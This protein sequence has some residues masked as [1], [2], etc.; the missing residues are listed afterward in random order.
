MV[1]SIFY[2][3]KLPPEEFTPG[4][5]FPG[6]NLKGINQINSNSPKIISLCLRQRSTFSFE[7]KQKWSFFLIKTLQKILLQFLRWKSR[8]SFGSSYSGEIF[9]G[10]KTLLNCLGQGPTLP[11]LSPSPDPTTRWTCLSPQS[12]GRN[13]ALNVL[14]ANCSNKKQPTLIAHCYI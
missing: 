14:R 12:F 3:L 8:V 11:L 1:P 9:F 10:V 13:E 2:S 6:F 4:M 7:D 5:L